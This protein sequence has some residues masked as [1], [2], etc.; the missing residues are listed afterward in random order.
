MREQ[1]LRR[2]IEAAKEA[3]D[4]FKNREDCDHNGVKYVPNDEMRLGVELD[5][6]LADM[7]EKE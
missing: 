6:A 7:G 5:R 2:L 3:R 1:A 4:W